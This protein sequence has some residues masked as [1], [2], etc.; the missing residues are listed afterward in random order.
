VWGVVFYEEHA[1]VLKTAG[2]GGYGVVHR[3]VVVAREGLEGDRASDREVVCRCAA[4][5]A[6]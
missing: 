6:H 1:S 2:G 3:D 5:E 4:F